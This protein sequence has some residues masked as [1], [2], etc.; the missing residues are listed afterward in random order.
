MSFIP[1]SVLR[2]RPTTGAI[3]LWWRY[4][5]HD[6][7]IAYACHARVLYLL[8]RCGLKWSVIPACLP[9]VIMLHSVRKGSR[10][11]SQVH[12]QVE[13]KFLLLVVL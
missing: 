7:R 11:G 12:S 8:C 13:V 2:K 6:H 3:S 5:G 9:T 10:L 4:F 1:H